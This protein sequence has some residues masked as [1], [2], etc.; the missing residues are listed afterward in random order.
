MNIPKTKTKYPGIE[1]GEY[2]DRSGS[3]FFIF[4]ISQKKAEV[5][6][7]H[8]LHVDGVWRGSTLNEIGEYSG[9]FPSLDAA[10]KL[11]ES[12]NF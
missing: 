10:E 5:L 11:L 1:I 12:V 9:Y 3:R 7:G 8:Y 6:V 2:K 4:R